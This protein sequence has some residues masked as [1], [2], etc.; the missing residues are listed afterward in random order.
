MSRLLLRRALAGTA[1]TLII[2]TPSVALTW[3]VHAAATAPSRST[4]QVVAPIAVAPVPAPQP[5]E[6][7]TRPYLTAGELAQ[8]LAIMPADTLTSTRNVCM[9]EGRVV[10]TNARCE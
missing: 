4:P 2:I 1:L 3:R 6:D 10:F 8:L 9:H 7:V 5:I